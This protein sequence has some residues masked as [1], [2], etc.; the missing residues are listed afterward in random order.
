M[1]MTNRAK[2]VETL[3][4]LLAAGD[5]EKLDLIGHRM[6]G[7]GIP[8]G[9]EKVSALA[10]RSRTAPKRADRFGISKCINEYADYLERVRIVV[11][12]RR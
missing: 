6:R 8:Y 1:F 12:T 5:L 11:E 7:V 2:E 10:S 9:F 3:R 4:G